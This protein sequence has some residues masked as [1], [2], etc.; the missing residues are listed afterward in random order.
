MKQRQKPDDE[1]MTSAD[2]LLS[3]IGARTKA[4]TR[5]TT[6]PGVGAAPLEE[7]IEKAPSRPAGA[8]KPVEKASNGPAEATKPVEKVPDD[9]TKATSSEC[10]GTGKNT[11]HER[12]QKNGH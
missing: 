8:T 10:G 3:S 1:G 2:R 5:K 9:L 6:Q 12:Q 4:R 11:G 7:K